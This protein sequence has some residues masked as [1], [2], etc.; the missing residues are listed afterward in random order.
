MITTTIT[1][2][3]AMA[4]NHMR[5]RGGITSTVAKLAHHG[6]GG[7]WVAW[8]LSLWPIAHPSG[9]GQHVGLELV[10]VAKSRGGRAIARNCS[11]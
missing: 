2:I 7:R 8:C 10:V 4:T 11:H 9:A 5:Y 1:T 3:A 6:P